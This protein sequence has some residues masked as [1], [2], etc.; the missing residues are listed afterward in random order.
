M[1]ITSLL[2]GPPMV[3]C[4]AFNKNPFNIPELLT[5]GFCPI[6]WIYFSKERRRSSCWF[7]VKGK[8]FLGG[9]NGRDISKSFVNCSWRLYNCLY[10]TVQW[11]NPFIWML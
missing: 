5:I 1:S 9:N 2:D 11:N 8:N 6:V 3:S 7:V 10:L 4:W